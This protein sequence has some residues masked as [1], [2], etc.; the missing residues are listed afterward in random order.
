M[1]E[2]ST[3]SERARARLAAL[4]VRAEH[5]AE[6]AQAERSR[7]AS[8]DALFEVF[9]RDAEVGG[10]IMA[11]ALAY[12]LFIWLL[13]LA[14]VLVAGLGLA[15]TADSSSPESVASSTGLAGLASSSVASAANS[16]ARWYALAVG[17]PILLYA[18]RSVLRTLIVAHRLVWTDL[19]ARAPR[20]TLTAS[21]RLLAILLAMMAVSVV[22]ATVRHNSGPLGLVA[23][24]ATTVPYAA[25]WLLLSMHLPHR[26]ATWQALVPGAVLFGVGIEV[27]HLVTVYFIG[28]FA[29]NKQGTYGALGLAAA[30]LLELFLLS[31]LVVATAALNATLWARRSRAAEAAQGK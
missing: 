2:P 24:L 16:S 20:P 23:T 19:R 25:L 26:D 4:H 27:L 7:H 11:G 21:A 9:D 5:V 15:A 13:P 6:R 12:R 22:S 28:P 29:A 8:L 17:I 31:R 14:L 30:L 3:A 10:G 1:D 18:T